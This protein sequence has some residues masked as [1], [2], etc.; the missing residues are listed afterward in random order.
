MM[1]VKPRTYVWK[2][3]VSTC[4]WSCYTN[5]ANLAYKA[6]RVM[7]F[8]IMTCTVMAIGFTN[9]GYIAYMESLPV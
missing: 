7:A 2:T 8:I 5:S 1:I 3:R 6:Y 4:A 9:L